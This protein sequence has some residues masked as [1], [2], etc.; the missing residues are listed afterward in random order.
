M[1]IQNTPCA[2]EAQEKDC[3]PVKISVEAELVIMFMATA[4]VKGK[5]K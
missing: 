4:L 5:T 1:V 3:H 2:H